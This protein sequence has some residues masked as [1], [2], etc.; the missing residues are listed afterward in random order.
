MFIFQKTSANGFAFL[1]SLLGNF[2]EVVTKSFVSLDLKK[3]KL[4]EYSKSSLHILNMINNE[5]SKPKWNQ[6][7]NEY[8]NEAQLSI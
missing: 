6:K 7:Q 3:I 1:L 2:S 4:K 5:K 8:V